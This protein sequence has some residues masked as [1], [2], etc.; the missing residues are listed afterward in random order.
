MLTILSLESQA[1]ER[2]FHISRSANRNIV[3]YDVH[4]TNG[5]LDCNEPIHV[6]WHNNED[7]PGM[8]DELSFIQ[9]KMAYGYK[10]VSITP[11]EAQVQLTAY[12]HRI[13][14]VFRHNNEWKCKVLI[15]DTECL[16]TEI[17]VKAN[18]HN[19]L[20]VEYVEL[21]GISLAD[22]SMLVEQILA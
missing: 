4:L 9:R 16:L 8:E 18:P 14:T 19:S 10:V 22:G 6:Y 21:H 17:Y 20:K 1:I 2:L 12:K 11:N 3:C 5:Q 7:R 13:V 15:N